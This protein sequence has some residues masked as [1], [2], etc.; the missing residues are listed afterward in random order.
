MCIAELHRLPCSLCDGVYLWCELQFFASRNWCL[1]LPVCGTTS[2][3]L[4]VV[5][6]GIVESVFVAR[7]SLMLLIVS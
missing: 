3:S 5:V 2:V 7:M 4:V 6:S 1:M